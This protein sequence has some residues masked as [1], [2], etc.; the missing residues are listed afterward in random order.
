M[1]SLRFR[2]SISISLQKDKPPPFA[3][4][5]PKLSLYFFYFKV[6]TFV[7]YFVST[8]SCRWVL[9]GALA[10]PGGMLVGAE[11]RIWFFSRQEYGTRL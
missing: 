1:L 5:T 10:K 9:G 8:I 4:K 6:T 2:G 7:S 11:P 3:K